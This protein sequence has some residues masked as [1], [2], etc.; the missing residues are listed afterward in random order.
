MVNIWIGDSHC[1]QIQ[2][3][4]QMNKPAEANQNSEDEIVEE[5][6][7]DDKANYLWFTTQAKYRLEELYAKNCSII[8]MIGLADCIEL[9]TYDALSIGQLTSDYIRTIKDLAIKHPSS[10]FY[11]CTV[12]PVDGNYS[13]A[14]VNE[15]TIT[16]AAL[17]QKIKDF[18]LEIKVLEEEDNITF[19]DTF[20]YLNSTSFTTYDGIHYTKK[21]VEALSSFVTNSMT[22]TT[23]VSNFIPRT[24]VP[25]FSNESQE[26]NYW[27]KQGHGG[28][29]PYPLIQTYQGKYDITLPNC[30]AWAYGRFYEILGSKPNLCISSGYTHN[31]EYWYLDTADGYERGDTPQVGAVICWRKFGIGDPGAGHVAIVEKI[32]EDGSIVVSESGYSWNKSTLVKFNTYSNSNGN[33]G[34]SAPYKFQGFI[35]CPAVVPTATAITVNKSQVITHT[36]ALKQKEME[37]NAKYIYKVLG[38]KGW[39]LNAVAGLL[40]NLEHESWINPGVTELGGT[41]FGLVQWT[42]PS[43]FTKWCDVQNPPLP[44]D[45]V[46]SQLMRLEHERNPDDPNTGICTPRA[47]YSG[48]CVH[49]YWYRTRDAYGDNYAT[50]YTPK[51]FNEFATSTKTPYELA[52]AFLYNYE[53]P[54][55]ICYGA[56]KDTATGRSAYEVGKSKT[57]AEREI[58]RANTRKIRGECAEKWYKILAPYAVAAGPVFTA[59]ALKIDRLTPTSATAS[60]LVRSGASGGYKIY[61]SAKSVVVAGSLSDKIDSEGADLNIVSFT[62]ESLTPN[63]EYTLEVSIEGDDEEEAVL[64]A[65][66]KTPQDKPKSIQNIIFKALDSGSSNGNFEL[67]AGHLTQTEWGYWGKPATGGYTVQLIINGKIVREKELDSLPKTFKLSSYF[68]YNA[69]LDDIIQIGIRTWVIYNGKK[70]YDSDFA[71]C[72]NTVCMLTKPITAYINTK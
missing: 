47:V 7:A 69:K 62:A 25:V 51:T 1:R 35:Y 38:S 24:T 50:T 55:S 16:A 12:N 63:E 3:N 21:T 9:C 43:K 32:N 23:A 58:T 48:G 28:L 5:Y 2:Q 65:V 39:T 45:D 13:S 71:E 56:H 30:T 18:N 53:C 31:A 40:G 44:H 20:N 6:I 60:F 29:N 61:N 59:A 49:G 15:G 67:T 52:C 14:L 70:L 10:N 33:W 17:N 26:A 57:V 41:G 64:T 42:P 22:T 19:L 72:S 37:I 4:Y 68:S 36:G 11:I 46:D 8:L 27:I 54:G 66:L 34:Y